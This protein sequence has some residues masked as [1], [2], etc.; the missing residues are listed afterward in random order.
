MTKRPEY[1]RCV[2]HTHKEKLNSSW[3]GKDLYNFDIP[4]VDVDHALYTRMSDGRLLI[5]PECRAEIK[6]VLD[7]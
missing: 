7:S 3:C 4:F 6:R 1:I 5:C 2:M